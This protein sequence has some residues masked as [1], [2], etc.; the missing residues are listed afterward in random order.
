[1]VAAGS[2]ALLRRRPIFL[3]PHANRVAVRAEGIAE[4]RGRLR[5]PLEGEHPFVPGIAG[6]PIGFLPGRG[7]PFGRHADR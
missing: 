1:L 2:C 6:E 5:R 3:T 4:S 7:G